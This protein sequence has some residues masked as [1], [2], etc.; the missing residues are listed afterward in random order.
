MPYYI[1]VQM[2]Q[3]ESKVLISALVQLPMLVF[4]CGYMYYTLQ[5]LSDNA[6]LHEVIALA[7]AVN[8]I[9][10]WGFLIYYIVKYYKLNDLNVNHKE[11]IQDDAAAMANDEVRQSVMVQL[12]SDKEIEDPKKAR[13]SVTNLF[14]KG[15][16][17]KT[18]RD[19][20]NLRE[21]VSTT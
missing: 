13:Q 17:L 7:E 3:L 8:G 20:M 4:G 14:N 21:S 2:L 18:S 10:G 5:Y 9:I 6:P 1:I 15:A 12:Q 16:V 11:V 19:F